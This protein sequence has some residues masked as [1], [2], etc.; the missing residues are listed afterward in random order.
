MYKKPKDVIMKTKRLVDLETGEEFESQVI[1]KD[2]N[3]D[4]DFKKVFF[5]ELVGIL[6]EFSNAKMKFILWL[7]DNLNDS[8]QF[9]GSYTELAEGSGISRDTIARVMPRMLETQVIKKIRTG[10][11]MLNPKLVASV[12]SQKRANL[13]VRYGRLK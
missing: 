9:Y 7:L 11:Y 8:N 12:N 10:T 1:V 2:F 3:N 13:L 6:D 4:A 5:A